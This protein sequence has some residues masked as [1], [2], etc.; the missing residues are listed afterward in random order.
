M[1]SPLRSPQFDP[2]ATGTQ[3]LSF[4]RCWGLWLFLRLLMSS[5][6]M[7]KLAVCSYD[8]F[9]LSGRVIIPLIFNLCQKGGILRASK[10]PPAVIVCL[11]FTKSPSA[12][13][14]PP[15]TPSYIPVSAAPRAPLCPFTHAP[16]LSSPR[17]AGSFR[18]PPLSEAPDPPRGR[19]GHSYA[20]C[21]KLLWVGWWWGVSLRWF[22]GFP[23][24]A[25]LAEG[26]G[27]AAIIKSIA[28]VGQ[29][30]RCRALLGLHS[31]VKLCLRHQR[32]L[33]GPPWDLKQIPQPC[34]LWCTAPVMPSTC[35]Q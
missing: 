26:V 15:R 9:K 33:R 19:S 31:I 22:K 1:V 17:S 2:T 5:Y 27:V 4:N 14:P 28:N 18:G 7:I 21:P 30:V 20:G 32:S 16:H 10:T 8:N 24:W 6:S 35:P 25:L 13:C 23:I 11:L 3:Q 12:G 34:H 29:G